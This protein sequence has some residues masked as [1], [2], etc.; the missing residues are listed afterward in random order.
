MLNPFAESDASHAEAGAQKP[1]YHDYQS[2]IVIRSTITV[3]RSSEQRLTS[4]SSRVDG[5]EHRWKAHYGCR[6]CMI[7][8]DASCAMSDTALNL[9]SVLFPG[10]FL[11]M[12]HATDADHVVAIATIVS[13]ERTLAGSRIDRSR[14]GDR[15]HY[16][17][18]GGRG[19]DH[20]FRRRHSAAPR[21]F[22]EF[23]VGVM[24]VM[25]G[26][27]TSDRH[28]PHHRRLA[29]AG[30]RGGRGL[31]CMTTCMLMATTCTSTRTATSRTLTA[32][33]STRRRWRGSTAAGLAGSA[34]TMDA[35]VCGR[36]GARS[37]RIRRTRADGSVDHSRYERGDRL[38]LLFGLGT[39]GG[40][41]LITL[42]LSAPFAFMA[43][44]CRNSIGGCAWR[45][46]YQFRVRGR[47]DLRYRLYKGRAVHRRPELAA[48][49]SGPTA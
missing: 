27:L 10:F 5:A 34:S 1:A 12:R 25:L 22:L 8:R 32:T 4:G 2:H 41:M 18:H 40:M 44:T 38:L 37:C 19:R 45:Q 16:H 3:P 42:A 46:A 20:R 23:A 48:A 26:V 29:G 39:I 6:A 43:R 35:A 24:L 33:P 7:S 28:G 47:S 49:L 21:P 30:A 9:L 31:I 13:R 14:L 15:A 11:G 17:S 36:P